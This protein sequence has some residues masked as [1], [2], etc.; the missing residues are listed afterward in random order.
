[1]SARVDTTTEIDLE[2]QLHHMESVKERAAYNMAAM[3]TTKENKGKRYAE[4]IGVI[5]SFCVQRNRSV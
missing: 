4:H 3:Y 5:A 1:M 2:M